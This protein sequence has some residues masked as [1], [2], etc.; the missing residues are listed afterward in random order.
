M[1]YVVMTKSGIIIIKKDKRIRIKVHSTLQRK[2]RE[3]GDRN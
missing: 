2:H 3:I 1:Y